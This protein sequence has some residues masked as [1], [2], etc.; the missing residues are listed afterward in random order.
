[1]ASCSS[2]FQAFPTEAS[3]R[4]EPHA[5]PRGRSASL[6]TPTIEARA[7]RYPTEWP[8]IA[9]AFKRFP[10]EIRAGQYPTECP[11]TDTGLRSP[12]T[13]S[14]KK[15]PVFAMGPMC[16]LKGARARQGA[17]INGPLWMRHRKWPELATG[18]QQ[19]PREATA[20]RPRI[21][22]PLIAMRFARSPKET[23]ANRATNSNGQRML[24]GFGG[25]A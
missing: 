7:G 15:R 18:T 10:I 2:R 20:S 23:K 4:W 13:R 5:M 1:M 17:R 11:V 3:E 12:S 21:D 8:L 14:E 16:S 9:P 22:W 6:A 19:Y 24:L 25:P